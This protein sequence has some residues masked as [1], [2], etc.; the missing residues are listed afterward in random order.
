L[1]QAQLD[2]AYD[3]TQHA[4]NMTEVMAECAT[5]SA[6]A[7]ALLKAQG[8]DMQRIAYGPT[9]VETLDWY[10][11]QTP[12]APLVFFVH[13]GAWRRGQAQDYAM[14]AAWLHPLGVQLVVPDF[15]AVTDVQGSLLTMVDQ[16]Q[17]ALTFTAQTAADLGANPQ[18]IYVVGHSSGAHL[19]ACLGATDWQQQGINAAPIHALMCCSGMYE[20]EPVSLSARSQYVQFNPKTLQDLSPQRH[21][22]RFKMPIALLCGEQESPEF[23]RQAQEF[24]QALS[25]K[26][27]PLRVIWGQGLN[28]FEILKSFA[29]PDGVM[30]QALLALMQD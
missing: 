28:H 27:A 8:T 30:S 2:W 10:P 5:L 3:Q 6:Q 19:A 16:L 20:L 17:R 23:K 15:S 4:S 29:N 14:A 7:R 1:T 24:A 26:D 12:N 25:H 22:H 9:A 21:V 11:S 18:R 13:G